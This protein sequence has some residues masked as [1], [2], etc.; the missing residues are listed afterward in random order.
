M[1]RMARIVIPGIPH[2][3]TQR[4]NRRQHVFFCDADYRL[5]RQL[6]AEFCCKHQVKVLAYCL[7]PNHSHLVLRP[8]DSDGLHRSVGEAHRRYTRHINFSHG[9]RGYLWQG[10]FAS[11]PMDDEHLYR[12]VRYVELYPVAAK[13][14]RRPEEWPW[15][16]AAAHLCGKN[17][18]LVDVSPM[19][20]LVPD[21]M[22]YL[23]EGL[24]N[25]PEVFSRHERTGR[26]L[27]SD[28]FVTG[29]EKL[30]GRRL[31]PAKAGRKP[32]GK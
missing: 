2:H 3:V 9:W 20:A 22:D 14:C 24:D 7:M 15:S 27:G 26:P 18:D 11:F 10:R 6:M 30:C 32:G 28:S 8:S 16:S 29:L 13:L 19:L 25:E 5:Y 31:R 12:A 17:D 1:A 4:G 23:A 21:W